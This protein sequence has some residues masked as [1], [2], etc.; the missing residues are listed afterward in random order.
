[1]QYL[2][3]SANARCHGSLVGPCPLRECS[4]WNACVLFST[5]PFQPSNVAHAP[6]S[7][8]LCRLVDLSSRRKPA[9]HM[10]A[11]AVVVRL[12]TCHLRKKGK[13]HEGSPISMHRC[14]MR[15]DP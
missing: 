6:D 11:T 8:I 14:I 7:S 15:S 2:S 3:L 12:D 9:D 13:P 4:E 10:T 1:M 5:D